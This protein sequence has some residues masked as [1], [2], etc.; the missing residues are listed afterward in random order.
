M[1]TL[2]F[3]QAVLPPN[4]TTYLVLFPA[5]KEFKI[6]KPY[7]SLEAMAEAAKSYSIDPAYKAVYH[8][9]AGYKAPYVEIEKDGQ[10]K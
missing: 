1:D 9:C 6:H 10:G 3:F 7:D 5:D 2:Q 8:A 4:G